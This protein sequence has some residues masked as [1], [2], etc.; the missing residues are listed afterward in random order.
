MVEENKDTAKL[1]SLAE[2]VPLGADQ[3]GPD[4]NPPPPST[5][6][7]PEPAEDK[8]QEQKWDKERQERDQEHANERKTLQDQIKD[9]EAERR[10][11][12]VKMDELAAEPPDTKPDD[13]PLGVDSEYEKLIDNANATTKTVHEQAE[14]LAE[15]RTKLDNVTKGRAADKANSDEK[16]MVRVLGGEFGAQHQNE[17]QAVAREYLAKRGYTREKPAHPDTAW[18]AYRLA[19]SAAASRPAKKTETD[20]SITVDNVTGGG[21][22]QETLSEGSLDDIAAAMKQGK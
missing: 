2:N 19:F 14:A 16:E 7:E 15:L 17:A 5:E 20:P 12:Q 3:P 4:Y 13:D 8:S 22:P 9:G 11:L 1:D 21:T 6:K 10:A 18:L